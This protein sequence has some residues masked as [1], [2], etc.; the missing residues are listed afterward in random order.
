MINTSNIYQTFGHDAMYHHAIWLR[1]VQSNP[2]TEWQ[3]QYEQKYSRKVKQFTIIMDMGGLSR[4]NMSPSLITLGQEVSR[5]VQD[6]YP[7]FTKRM[8]FVRSPAIF[9][10][11]FNAFKPFIDEETRE[12]IVFLNEKTYCEDIKQF[13]DP[14]ILPP[15]ICPEGAGQSIDEISTFW[16]GG[17]V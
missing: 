4:K 7:G 16:E 1:E 9:R 17:L 2:N 3:K 14:S 11:A 6:D 8:I 10:F 15:E 5:M 12:K 13:L